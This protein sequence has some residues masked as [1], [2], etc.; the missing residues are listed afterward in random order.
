MITIR[1]RLTL[2]YLTIFVTLGGVLLG[3]VAL[4]A[5]QALNA[6]TGSLSASL[7]ASSLWTSSVPAVPAIGPDGQATVPTPKNIRDQVAV[8]HEALLRELM[9]RSGLAFVV[10]AVLAGVVCWLVASRALRPLR[11]I[12]TVAGQ[13]SHETLDSRI[14]RHRPADELGTLTDTF[15]TML[16]RLARAFQAQRLFA[17][18]AS[19]ELRTP[20]TIIQAAAEKALSRPSRAEIEYRTALEVVAAAAHRS[21]RLLGSLL[22]LAR[23]QV[24]PESIDLAVLAIAAAGP[25][26]ELSAAPAPAYAD[27]TLV[28][29]VLRNL[30]DNA[31]RYNIEG[32]SVSVRTWADDRSAM[33]T[34]SNTGPLVD[35]ADLPGLREAFRRGAGR[36]GRDGFG[37]GLA[38]VDAIVDAHGG[39]WTAAARPGGGLDVTVNLPRAAGSGS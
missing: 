20:L 10:T 13:L 17:A 38:V 29:L 25:A 28:D 1:T 23:Q 36:T 33:L 32:G 11:T 22:L 3:C 21:E 9:L 15:N 14:P 31:A 2:W 6:S 7:V 26:T 39:T 8:A 30:L 35:E 4:L 19:H 5:R 12:T 27:P 16:D 18:N 37:L 24:R 34:V